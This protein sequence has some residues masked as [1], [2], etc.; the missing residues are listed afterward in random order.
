MK[1]TLEENTFSADQFWLRGV[2]KKRFYQD[3]V[4]TTVRF[5]GLHMKLSTLINY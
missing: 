2:F 5:I 1:V 3:E 4:Y